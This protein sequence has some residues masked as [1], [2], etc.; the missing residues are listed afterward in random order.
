[1]PDCAECEPGDPLGGSAKSVV[2]QFAAIG[3][4][5][6]G[7]TP[8]EFTHFLQAETARWIEVVAKANIRVAN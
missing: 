3:T 1:M 4:E 8:E 2:E 6:R 5:A 7:S